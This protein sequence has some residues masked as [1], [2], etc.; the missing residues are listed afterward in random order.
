VQERI[1]EICDVEIESAD[2]LDDA[3]KLKEKPGW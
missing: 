1:P 2:Q 3:D